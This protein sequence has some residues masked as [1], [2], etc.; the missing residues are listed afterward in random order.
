[1]KKYPIKN[2]KLG[3]GVQCYTVELVVASRQFDWLDKSIVSDKNNKRNTTYN[4]STHELASA[5]IQSIE[6]EN[7]TNRYSVTIEIKD[8]VR[9]DT[10]KYML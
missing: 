10:K 8:D 9:D 5:I 3:I 4:S 1:M 6:I 7:M 2:F